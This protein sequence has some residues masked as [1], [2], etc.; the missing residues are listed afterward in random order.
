MTELNAQIVL[1]VAMA[2]L[3]AFAMWLGWPWAAAFAAVLLTC[4]LATKTAR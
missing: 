2:A 4:I 3:M 1:A